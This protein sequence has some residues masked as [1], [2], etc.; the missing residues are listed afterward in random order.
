M[1]SKSQLKL[2]NTVEKLQN[3]VKTL[4]Q[5]VTLTKERSTLSQKIMAVSV[6]VKLKYEGIITKILQVESLN[7]K[8]Q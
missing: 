3:R 1:R 5:Q 7:E 8:V 4:E 6:D 2:H